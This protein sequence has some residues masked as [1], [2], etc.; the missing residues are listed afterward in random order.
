MIAATFESSGIRASRSGTP[1]DVG[2]ASV[3]DVE[4]ADLHLSV[5]EHVGLAGGGDAD[6]AA[7]RVC[8]LE[9]G[10]DDEVDVEL[11]LAPELDVLDVRRAD[12]RRRPRR[13]AAREHA[14]DEVHLVARGA[15]DDEVGVARRRRRRGLRLVPSPSKMAT[16]KR[17]GERLRAAKASVSRTVSSCSSWSASTIVDPTCPAPMRKTRTARVAYSRTAV[18]HGRSA[19][20]SS[21]RARRLV[22]LAVALAGR[23]RRVGD[24]GQSAFSARGSSGR[25]RARRA[26]AGRAAPGEPRTRLYVVEQRGTIRVVERGTIRRAVFLDVRAQVVAGGEQGLLGLAFDPSTRRTGRSYVNYT[27]RNGDT[28]V[29]RY[30]SNGDAGAA[31]QRAGS[32]CSSTSR[33]RN[34]NGG[35][36]LRAR[37]LAL[38]RHR[39]RRLGR[40][41]REPGAEHATPAREDAAP[42]RAAARGRAR[43]SSA[44]GLRNPWRYSFDR[45]PATSTS[46]T[47]ARA[48]RGGRLTAWRARGSRT[49]AGT[50]TRARRASRTRRSGPGK[51]VVPVAEYSHGEGCSVIGGYVY[52][53][54][55]VPA[56]A[57]RYFFGDYCSGT[58]WSLSSSAARPAVRQEPFT[59][60]SLTSFGEDAAG[61]LY[62]RL[63][64]NGMLFRLST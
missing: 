7:D 37:R 50:S 26:G 20:V 38:R 11:A 13:L 16:S 49:T 58:I 60:P 27:R 17:Y 32:C 1:S 3:V 22:A 25:P 31:R 62:A 6:D 18:A 15:R 41:P 28:R 23:A 24:C 35:T 21:V 39:R 54:K 48:R 53:G 61:E 44:L 2:D 9:L 34:H 42:R 59:V 52:R 12:H 51:L 46:A 36:R 14:R 47:S 43:R 33:T 56:A 5:G 29:V 45:R 64:G 19:T 40:R 4:L 63:A 30:R 57:G 55:A 10:G 8:G